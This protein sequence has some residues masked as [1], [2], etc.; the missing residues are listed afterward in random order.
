VDPSIGRDLQMRISRNY[1]IGFAHLIAPFLQRN[2][3]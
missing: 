1:L 2:D 3:I